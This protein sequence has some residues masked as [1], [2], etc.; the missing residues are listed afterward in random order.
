MLS[1]VIILL[2]FGLI[3]FL[4]YRLL[5]KEREHS[6]F[7]RWLS[8]N[9]IEEN[10]YFKYKPHNNYPYTINQLFEMYQKQKDGRRK[11]K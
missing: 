3:V 2:V 11:E 7:G 6:G 5:V 9:T 8:K 4:L 10:T 1:V